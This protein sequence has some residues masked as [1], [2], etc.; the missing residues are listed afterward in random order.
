MVLCPGH[1]IQECAMVEREG[2]HDP[3]GQSH[4]PV[5]GSHDPGD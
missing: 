1:C 3:D 4:D 5:G 2:S